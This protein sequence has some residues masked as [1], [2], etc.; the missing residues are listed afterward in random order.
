MAEEDSGTKRSDILGEVERTIGRP[1]SDGIAFKLTPGLA[2]RAVSFLPDNRPVD[3]IELPAASPLSYRPFPC[4]MLPEPLRRFVLE[5]SAAMCCDPGPLAT[6]SLVACSAA[7]GTTRRLAIKRTWRPYP[8]LWGVMMAASGDMKSPIVEIATQPIHDRQRRLRAEYQRAKEAFEAELADWKDARANAEQGDELPPKPEPP[9]PPDRLVTADA[10]VEALGSLLQFNPRGMLVS[11]D[12]LVTLLGGMDKYK[13]GSSDEGFYLSSYDGRSFTIDRKTGQPPSIFIPRCGLS[14]IGA[15][16]PAKAQ[17]TITPERR[18]SGLAQRVLW[19]M[20]PRRPYRWT[21]AEVGGQTLHNYGAVIEKLFALGD[22][23][24]EPEVLTLSPEA[25][26]AFVEWTEEHGRHC[27]AFSPD[28]AAAASKLR[29][30]PARLA[31]VLASI[32]QA[33]GRLASE[34]P[35]P[36]AIMLDAIAIARWFR[37]ETERV[38]RLLEADSLLLAELLAVDAAGAAVLEHLWRCDEPQS[39]SDIATALAPI[40]ACHV[41]SALADAW[42]R[43]AV[44]RTGEGLEERWHAEPLPEPPPTPEH[45]EFTAWAPPEP[46]AGQPEDWGV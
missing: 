36:G 44:H 8:L 11:V 20:P 42:H 43:G 3:E 33:A 17:A 38:Y 7:I 34:E 10:T 27:R 28:L 45:E 12:E 24:S 5:A 9:M 46:E 13:R 25:R 14:I 39:R 29:E 30:I 26:Q 35:M 16:Q 4:D 21:E 18:A 2:A 6:L 41:V 32:E 1:R 19:C 15:L 37:H 23:W 40:P 22:G 31:I